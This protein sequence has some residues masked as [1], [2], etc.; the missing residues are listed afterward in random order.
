MKKRL[1]AGLLCLTLLPV[2]GCSKAKPADVAEK[3]AAV[4]EETTAEEQEA[5][6][7][8]RIPQILLTEQQL[9]VSY[10]QHED[11]AA[12]GLWVTASLDGDS[13][14]LYPE[15]EQSLG[16]YANEIAAG[17]MGSFLELREDTLAYEES[18]EDI[19]YFQGSTEN[20][21]SVYRND[22]AVLSLLENRY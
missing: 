21:V 15:L 4:V 14:A 2:T 1:L 10:A 6:E 11:T 16:A 8:T 17:E 3:P 22:G 9:H 13:A 20:R 18:G 12:T 19:T 5:E 7:K